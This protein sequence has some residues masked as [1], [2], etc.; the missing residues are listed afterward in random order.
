MTDYEK[1]TAVAYKIWRMTSGKI[2]VTPDE[3]LEK[4]TD[5][6]LDFYYRRILQNV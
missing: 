1:A 6:E 2:L 4:C 3:I 5:S